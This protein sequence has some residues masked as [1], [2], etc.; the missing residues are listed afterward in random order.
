MVMGSHIALHQPVGRSKHS[1]A[2]ISSSHS[3]S[4]SFHYRCYLVD[5]HGMLVLDEEFLNVKNEEREKYHH[6]PLASRHGYILH[7]L[8]LEGIFRRHVTYNFQASCSITKNKVRKKLGS[9]TM[10][11]SVVVV[12]SYIQSIIFLVFALHIK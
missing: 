1:L 11:I 3:L 5:D 10:T 2:F 9:I 7:Q 12:L 8:L 4:I 6:K